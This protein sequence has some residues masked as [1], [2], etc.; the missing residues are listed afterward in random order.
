[1]DDSIFVA[2]LRCGAVLLM[3]GHGSKRPPSVDGFVYLLSTNDI[4]QPPTVRT[5]NIHILDEA[6]F[7]LFTSRPIR[8]GNNGMFVDAALYNHID[9]H[10]VETAFA[11]RVDTSQHL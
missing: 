4:T 10:R 1:V 6:K 5:T 7:E 11:G 8:H 2:E 9:L 3:G